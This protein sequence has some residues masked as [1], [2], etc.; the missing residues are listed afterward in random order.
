MVGFFFLSYSPIVFLC[1]G[2]V[3]R[4]MRE[5][6]NQTNQ[7]ASDGGDGPWPPVKR[8]DCGGGSGVGGGGGMNQDG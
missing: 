7:E 1:D 4:I 2:G 5:E 6:H 3:Y 8:I